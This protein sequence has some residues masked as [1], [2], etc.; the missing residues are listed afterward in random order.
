MSASAT[1]QTE[2]IIYNSQAGL[3]SRPVITNRQVDQIELKRICPV[4][5]IGVNP[6]R[7]DLGKCNFC[8]ECAKAFPLEI[9]FTDD[10]H[11]SSNVRDRLIVLEGEDHPI[12]S[13]GELVRSEV[14]LLDG[15]PVSL[16]LASA[17]VFDDVLLDKLSASTQQFGVA[18]VSSPAQAHGIVLLSEMTD[19][20]SADIRH[21]YG[22]LRP[23]R[24]VLLAGARAIN[25]G[26]NSDTRQSGKKIIDR[27]PVDLYVPGQP[28]HATT[29]ASAVR[30]LT[31]TKKVQLNNI[32]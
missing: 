5:A 6:V 18:F 19:T 1:S 9:Q 2:L 26:I 8:M 4:N 21:W 23:P 10:H 13:D 20:I 22:M 31:K 28:V 29:L 7:I 3:P 15:I 24:L 14:R 11:V 27:F 25:N 16:F 32:K 30:A 17:G 12:T